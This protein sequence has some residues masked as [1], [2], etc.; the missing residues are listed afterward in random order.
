MSQI[1]SVF[2]LTPSNQYAWVKLK[3]TGATSW[4]RCHWEK[5]RHLLTESFM[6]S[7]YGNSPFALSIHQSAKNQVLLSEMGFS[8]DVVWLNTFF[9]F[10]PNSD[11]QLQ[12]SGGMIYLLAFWIHWNMSDF[13]FKVVYCIFVVTVTTLDKRSPYRGVMCFLC[14]AFFWICPQEVTSGHFF[15]VFS[16]KCGVSKCSVYAF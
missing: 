7:G 5:A 1:R 4:A 9:S 6:V 2:K 10:L 16:H 11:I 3:N 14:L 15:P 13:T 12:C 8:G